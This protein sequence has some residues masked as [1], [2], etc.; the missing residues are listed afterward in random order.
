MSVYCVCNESI[1]MKSNDFMIVTFRSTHHQKEKNTYFFGQMSN[2]M[3]QGAEKEHQIDKPINRSCANDLLSD[4]SDEDLKNLEDVN[5]K[6]TN[7][8][9][10]RK[11]ANARERNYRDNKPS[12]SRSPREKE[13]K[14]DTRRKQQRHNKRSEIPRYDVRRIVRDNRDFSLSM[15][16]SRSRSRTPRSPVQHYH[17]RKSPQSTRRRYHSKSR[18]PLT[19]RRSISNRPAKRMHH[20][21]RDRSD[22][23]RRIR[24]DSKHRRLRRESKSPAKKKSSEKNH[25]NSKTNKKISPENIKII[26][27]NEDSGTKRSKVAKKDKKVKRQQR[28]SEGQH[29][30][31]YKAPDKPSQSDEI[32]KE[33]IAS[34]DNILIS[35]SYANHQAG[36]DDKEKSV[37][38]LTPDV[39]ER[40]K[41]PALTEIIARRSP[42]PPPKYKNTKSRE[43]KEKKRK[44]EKRISKSRNVKGQEENSKKMEK[45]LKRNELKPIAFIDL[46]KSPGKEM[47]P[48]PKEII[49]LSDS[50]NET[51]RKADNSKD[52]LQTEMDNGRPFVCIQ[53]QPVLKFSINKKSNLLPIKNLLH[54]HEEDKNEHNDNVIEPLEKPERHLNDVYDPFNPTNSKSNSPVG[55]LQVINDVSS[56]SDMIKN[57]KEKSPIEKNYFED[58]IITSTISLRND[59]KVPS[60]PLSSNLMNLKVNSFYDKNF[61][62]KNF[63][64]PSP[65]NNSEKKKLI[66]DDA[67]PYSPCS[68]GYEPP[69]DDPESPK[70]EENINETRFNDELKLKTPSKHLVQFKKQ[71][72]SYGNR[73]S[74]SKNDQSLSKSPNIKKLS[75]TVKS[76]IKRYRNSLKE[77]DNSKLMKEKVGIKGK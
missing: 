16:R 17:R 37:E 2:V 3:D 6:A 72:D 1:R 25:K 57:R 67:T 51:L 53:S 76:K 73:K 42:S 58:N 75:N 33:I 70:E 31:T 29:A 11:I 49:V 59:K 30:H 48:S 27:Q 19:R 13:K 23:R 4:I 52:E 55:N 64:V 69:P 39:V 56:S 5:S 65:K 68:D 28:N 9:L 61:E 18:S 66:E 41:S 12:N 77:Y 46:D 36:N 47:L 62:F 8:R 7:E 74:A 45:P 22:D 32:S 60:S 43:R 71:Q 20:T 24:D 50:D 26:L 21:S 15:S 63:K 38:C 35:V 34:G 54:D 10:F 14:D 44:K 40:K